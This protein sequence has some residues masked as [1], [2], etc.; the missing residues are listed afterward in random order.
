MGSI[1]M[2]AIYEK[3]TGMRV[4][5][6]GM[7]FIFRRQRVS[8]SKRDNVILHTI[9]VGIILTDNVILS[10]TRPFESESLSLSLAS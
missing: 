6:V 1:R 3:E 10:I 2:D 9:C 5:C 4:I 7:S 8:I